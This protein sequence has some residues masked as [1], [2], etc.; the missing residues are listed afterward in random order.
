M[1]RH[2]YYCTVIPSVVALSLAACGD[3]GNPIAT[4]QVAAKVGSEEI[5]VHQINQVLSRASKSSDSPEA[6]QVLTREILEKLIDQ[7]LAIDQATESKLNRSPQVI[8]ELEAA[9]RDVL[10]RAYLQQMASGLPKPTPEE[11]KSYFTDHPQLFA[12]RRIF[13]LQEIIIPI[14]PGL[15]EQLRSFTTNDKTVEEVSAWLK[16][17]NIAFTTGN[18][19]RAA[20][21]IPLEILAKIHPLNT[22]QSAVLEATKAITFLHIAASQK[23]PITE[24]A[25]SAGIEKYLMSQRT[26][27]A[28]AKKLKELRANTQITY[29]GEFAKAHNASTTPPINTSTTIEKGV[30]GLK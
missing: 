22:G 14:A 17:K 28:L 16:G 24:A 27:E 7:Q 4:T 21:Q 15:V 26:D 25:A 9:R 23:A 19:S 1:K 30:A 13:N 6:I 5:S 3:K 2:L 8:A 10:A 11:I 29:M 20:E 18:A 12:E